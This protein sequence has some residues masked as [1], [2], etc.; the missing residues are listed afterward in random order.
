[1]YD[2]QKLEYPRV[3]SYW[4]FDRRRMD[5]GPLPF[6]FYGPMLYR[7]YRWSKDNREEI[8]RGW[9]VQGK[10]IGELAGHLKMDAKVLNKT[11]ED[12]NRYCEQREDLDFHR[13]PQDLVP[14]Q[15]PP[16]FA[17][18]LW[19]GSANTQGGPRR[20]HKAQVLNTRGQPIPGL[21]AAG[22]FGSIYGMLYPG[23]GGNLAECFAFGRIAAENATKESK[24]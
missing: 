21:Y 24:K 22:E 4:I 9:I 12:Y 14:I 10:T 15:D 17:V 8:K 1:L 16:F 23:T 2:S 5:A 3:P 19:P 7:L 6:M 13:P 18:S 20:N 11:V